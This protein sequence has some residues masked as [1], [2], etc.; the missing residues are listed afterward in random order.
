MLEGGTFEEFKALYEIDQLAPGN[1]QSIMTDFLISMFDE[2]FGLSLTTI[3]FFH[4]SN[5]W[6]LKTPA[7]VYMQGTQ[8]IQSNNKT[9]SN[10]LSSYLSGEYIIFGFRHTITAKSAY[11]EFALTKNTFTTGLVDDTEEE[12]IL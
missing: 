2:T 6:N 10:K 12:E 11:S 7:I 1:P 3:P 5:P 4:I 9:S 8:I